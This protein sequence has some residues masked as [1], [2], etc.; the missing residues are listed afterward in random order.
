MGQ[1]E[2]KMEVANV[3]ELCALALD[4]TA[5]CQGL[6]LWT[7][8]IATRCI[9]DRHRMA[10]VAL[11]FES[12]KRRG[13]ALSQRP[14]DAMLL[15]AEPMGRAIGVASGADDVSEFQRRSRG[16]RWMR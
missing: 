15:S 5:L 8:A 2:H 13:A 12:A 1:G 14:Q 10:V 7:V 11:C 4:P 3:E 16:R 6:T 9:L